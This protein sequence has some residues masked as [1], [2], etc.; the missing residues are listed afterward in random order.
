MASR[1]S[2]QD[3][4][5]MDHD[6]VDSRL[7]RLAVRAAGCSC[8]FVHLTGVC[9]FVTKVN[10]Y[11]SPCFKCGSHITAT[12]RTSKFTLRI[13]MHVLACVNSLS[14]TAMVAKKIF[15]AKFRVWFWSNCGIRSG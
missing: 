11:E 9:I 1:W 8:L 12:I 5:Q 7:I 3:E 15:A 10:T 4:Q 6:Q 2:E 13:P 14:H